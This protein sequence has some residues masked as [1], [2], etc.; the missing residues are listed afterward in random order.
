MAGI[1]L[2]IPFCRQ[3]C[4]Y[5][6]FYFSTHLHFKESFLTA[7]ETEIER[8]KDFLSEPIQTVYFGGGTPSQLSVDEL[9]RIWAAL[10]HSFDLS[11]VGEVTLEA[12]PDNLSED[13]LNALAA[14]PINRLSVGIQ[15]FHDSDLKMLNRAHSGEQSLQSI[16]R[17]QELGFDE[18]SLDLIYGLPGS[19]MESWQQNLDLAI[20][21]NVDHVSSYCLTIEP[22]TP[23]EHAIKKGRLTYPTEA[24]I[25]RQF[26]ALKHSLD[27]AGY[28]HYEISNFAKP[29]KYAQHN[30]SY[31]KGV[32][33]LGLGPS[34]HAYDGQKR[35][36]NLPD[37]RQYVS[38]LQEGKVH[39]ESEELDPKDQYNE[40]IMTHLRTQWGIDLEEVENLFGHNQQ[41]ELLREIET[42]LQQGNVV[43]A[44]SKL[45]LTFEG[46][47]LA[48]QIAA[49]LFTTD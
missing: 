46:Q 14:S 25:V 24:E 45:T 4:S 41:K 7:L 18:I 26:K 20:S 2:H 27:R 23:L 43:R 19:T 30:T 49:D 29:G 9:K 15:S 35:Y 1:Y 11:Q 38:L 8:R 5:C 12:N 13:Y 10:S 47:L 16:K 31:W 32:N 28:E 42:H 22:K 34:A 6:D 48:D 3:A 40:Y 36:W 21:L 17:A 33:Y 39:Y 37:T 44:E